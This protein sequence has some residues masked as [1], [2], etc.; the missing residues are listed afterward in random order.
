VTEAILA[1]VAQHG[2][3]IVL[4][5]TFA[6][7]LALPIPSSLALM[8]AGSFVAT[9]EMALAAAASA[10]LAGAIIGDQTGYW[11][12]AVGGP[13]VEAL[14]R[15]RGM[16]PAL[17]A[18]RALSERWGDWSVF[19]SRWLFSPLGPSVNLISGMIGA[20]WRRFTLF[21]V[22]GEIVWVALYMALG[23]AF[24]RSI[25]AIAELTGD[26]SWFL[27]AGAAALVFALMLRR[28][29]GRVRSGQTGR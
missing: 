29:G 13:G 23:I 9:G 15:R 8:A 12:G 7:C 14:A 17:A 10:A 2:T 21:A 4:A 19:L 24:S 5:A 26:L 18:A 25:V 3:L 27:V 22:L 20:P 16:T 28:R 1:L 11:L 6:S